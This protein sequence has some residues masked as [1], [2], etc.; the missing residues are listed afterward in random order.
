MLWRCVLSS[1]PRVDHI[2]RLVVHPPGVVDSADALTQ[3]GA[4]PLALGPALRREYHTAGPNCVTVLGGQGH[5]SAPNSMWDLNPSP[6]FCLL[7]TYDSLGLIWLHVAVI[8]GWQMRLG[9]KG[10]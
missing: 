1:T 3:M 6:K 2:R 7:T 4:R 10:V 5:Q 8:W 9:I